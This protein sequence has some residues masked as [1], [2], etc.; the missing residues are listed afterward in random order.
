MRITKYTHSC[1]VVEENDKKILIDPGQYTFEAGDLTDAVLTGVDYCVVTHEHFDHFHEPAIRR[2]MDLS[3]QVVF[4]AGPEVVKK[5]KTIGV[6]ADSTSDEFISLEVGE[7]AH[8]WDGVPV[9]E[10]TKV[11]IA[12]KLLH[13]GDSMDA[14]STPEV[15]AVPFFGP[16]QNGTVTDAVNLI[17][18]LQPPFVIPIHDWHYN[19]EARQG[20][21]QRISEAVKTDNITVIGTE[22]GKA[23]DLPE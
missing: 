16:W 9:I 6:T 4:K 11:T 18:K 15:L 3:P 23:Y 2:L 10:N 12:G 1:L 19:Q 5:F 20:F 17:K 8:L 13:V 7:H 22:I 14:T 21:L